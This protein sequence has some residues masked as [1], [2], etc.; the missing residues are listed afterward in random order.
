MTAAAAAASAT[1]APVRTPAE[2]FAAAEHAGRVGGWA[3][4]GS[5]TPTPPAGLV[6]RWQDRIDDAKTATPALA[7]VVHGDSRYPQRLAGVP[8]PPA[9][10]FT[11]GDTD[12]CHAPLT[13]AVVGSRRV[14]CEAAAAAS[15]L[16]AALVYAAAT[17]VSGLAAG[18]DTA[19]HL[20]ALNAGGSTVAVLGTGIGVVYPPQNSDLCTRIAGTGAL[21]S[22][23]PPGQPPTPGSFLARNAV[24]AGLC[25]VSIAVAAQSASGTRNE[26]DAALRFGRKVLLWAPELASQ[27]WAAQLAAEGRAVMVGTV[28]EAV[29]ACER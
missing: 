10:L 28:A 21:V 25:D 19:A 18:I 14:S 5:D 9:A 17:V 8:H 29:A 20:G 22:Q 27:R 2:I 24:I 15:Q 1:A 6:R 3:A 11:A 4:A 12:A 7:V 13:V 16:A 23:F 26:I